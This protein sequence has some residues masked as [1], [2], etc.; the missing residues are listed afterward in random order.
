MFVR[1]ALVVAL[2][3]VVSGP[4]RA[5]G[6][7]DLR[8]DLDALTLAVD[9][10]RQEQS[11]TRTRLE[12]LAATASKDSTAAEID[13]LRARLDTLDAQ[14]RAVAEKLGGADERLSSLGRD[15]DRLRLRVEALERRAAAPPAPGGGTAESPPAAGPVATTAATPSPVTPAG[16]ESPAQAFQRAYADYA[17]AHYDLAESGFQSFLRLPEAGDLADDAAYYL[18]EIEAA[19]GRTEAALNGYSRVLSDYPRG[20]KV[21]AAT[22]KKGLLLIDMNRLGEGIVQLD[23]LVRTY[24][25]SDE[26]RLARNKL[27]ALGVG[28]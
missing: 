12:A 2:L 14:V 25:Q 15:M 5:A 17:E 1:A 20:D 16:G 19:R 7:T 13:K 8:R 10:L 11:D 3:A 26:A 27:R 24:P 4:T 23:H 22:L 9:R 28:P 21:P 18:A 6:G